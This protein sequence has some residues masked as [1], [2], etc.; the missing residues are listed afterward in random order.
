MPEASLWKSCQAAVVNTSTRHPRH[1]IV[2]GSSPSTKKTSQVAS[3]FRKDAAFCTHLEMYVASIPYEPRKKKTTYL[4]F[5]LNPA[6]LIEVNRDP[7]NGL[8][9]SPHWVGCHPNMRQICRRFF[10]RICPTFND[11]GILKKVTFPYIPHTIHATR[12][13]I[14]LH[15]NHEN[16]PFM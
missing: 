14:Y 7:Y 13:Y 1:F 11:L 15:E 9:Y 6:W 4:H 12:T 16:Q 10:W 5:P 2:A 3:C 8:L